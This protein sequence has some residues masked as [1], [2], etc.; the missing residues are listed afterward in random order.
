MAETC[1]ERRIK[2]TVAFCRISVEI[3]AVCNNS[4]MGATGCLNIIS[5]IFFLFV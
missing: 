4:Y 3:Y 1:H 5:R 2:V